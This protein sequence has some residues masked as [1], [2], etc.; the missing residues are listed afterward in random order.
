LWGEFSFSAEYLAVIPADAIRED[1]GEKW[2]VSLTARRRK[3]VEAMRRNARITIP[4]LVA[5]LGPGNTAIDNHL[6]ALRLA[7]CIR[8]VGPA[9]RGRWEV[10]S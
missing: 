10:L 6:K 4:E 9:K 5:E 2:G 7:G 1:R 8:R 3:I